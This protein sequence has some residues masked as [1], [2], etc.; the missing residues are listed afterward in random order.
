MSK[1]CGKIRSFPRYATLDKQM[2]FS[3]IASFRSLQVDHQL[4]ALS[5]LDIT[6]DGREEVIACSWVRTKDNVFIF[7]KPN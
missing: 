6:G 3:W 1:F 4:F 2:I 5:K 7:K